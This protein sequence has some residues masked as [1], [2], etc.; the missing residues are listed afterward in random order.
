MPSI[1]LL[2][3]LLLPPLPAYSPDGVT[4]SHVR[5]VSLPTRLLIDDLAA[6]S[7]IVRQLLARLGCTDVQ[8][9]LYSPPVSSRDLSMMFTK[10]CK[11]S[12]AA[13]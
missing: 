8:G 9:L 5:G 11:V 12:F 13:A 4:A 2:T 7:A 6:Q 3:L 1:W 10:Q